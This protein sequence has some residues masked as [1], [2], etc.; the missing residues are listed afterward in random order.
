MRPVWRAAMAAVLL[1]A[2]GCPAAAQTP[3]RF[4]DWTAAIIAGD[5]RSTSGE[6]I[7]AFENAR[8]DL[9]HAFVQVGFDPDHTVSHALVPEGAI[10]KPAALASVAEIA[11][12]TRAGCFLYLTSHGDPSGIVFGP[13][14][15]LRPAEL[16]AW[17]DVACGA[18]PT[19]V[20]VSACYS[21][22]FLPALRSVEEVVAGARRVAVFDGM[23]DHTN[24][25][26]A[27]RS[28][29]A[30]G[31]DA[32]LNI[33]ESSGSRLRRR[34]SRSAKPGASMVSTRS[35]RRSVISTRA[36]WLSSASLTSKPARR[37]AK[38][39]ISRIG[40]SSS[41]IRIWRTVALP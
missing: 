24:L 12:A 28:A 7:Q 29:A 34:C 9:T 31:V 25:G 27:F 18:R 11:R 10:D 37:S 38:A 5:W 23:V 21:G 40:C 16:D 8:R 30:L 39:I 17:L 6:P 15:R 13:T 1:F 35:G 4:S 20:V 32:V 22:G 33:A 26:A 41:T 14:G 2:A 3:S 36:R 19:V